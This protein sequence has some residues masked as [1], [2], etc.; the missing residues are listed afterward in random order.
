[1]SIQYGQSWESNPQSSDHKSHHI[2][3][4]TKFFIVKHMYLGG[5]P[6]QKTLLIGFFHS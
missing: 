3:S 4:Y 6:T 1:M 5:S 2:A